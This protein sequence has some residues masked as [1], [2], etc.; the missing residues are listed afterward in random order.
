[1]CRFLAVPKISQLSKLAE[2]PPKSSKSTKPTCNPQIWG[3][4]GNKKCLSFF[5]SAPEVPF[6][7]TRKQALLQSVVTQ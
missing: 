6:F 3:I 1:M 5:G 4:I 7:G 2:N